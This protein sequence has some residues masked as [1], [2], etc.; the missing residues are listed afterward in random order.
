MNQI[1]STEN[2]NNRMNSKEYGSYKSKGPKG[3]TNIK[4]IIIIFAIAIIVLGLIIGI[5]FA[6][7]IYKNRKPTEVEKPII[8]LGETG[9]GQ[10]TIQVKSEIGLNKLTY[11]KNILHIRSSKII[12]IFLCVFLC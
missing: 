9:E 6:F 12:T 11:Y 10:A 4:S 2:P 3:P 8:V 5:I 1:L 7:R